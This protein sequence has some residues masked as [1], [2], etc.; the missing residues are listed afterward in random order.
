MLFYDAALESLKNNPGELTDSSIETY[1][2]NLKKLYDFSGS[3]STC[4][5]GFATLFC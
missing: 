4:V 5:G 1:Q 3:S 2:W